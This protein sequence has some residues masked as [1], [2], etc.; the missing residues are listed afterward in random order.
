M[1]NAELNNFAKD[2]KIT[3]LKKFQSNTNTDL[4]NKRRKTAD[5]FEIEK[6]RELSKSARKTTMPVSGIFLDT[7]IEE[8]VVETEAQKQSGDMFKAENNPGKFS[9][10]DEDMLIFG[11]CNDFEQQ[12]SPDYHFNEIMS[13]IEFEEFMWQDGNWFDK[14]IEYGVLRNP[15]CNSG[16]S[17]SFFEE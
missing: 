15:G 4:K 9:H 13:K 16:T 7:Q 5:A 11:K 3:D 10:I 17:P 2:L 12:L 8:V 1:K 14:P 6:V